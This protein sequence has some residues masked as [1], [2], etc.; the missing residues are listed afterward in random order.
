MIEGH[1]VTKLGPDP[2]ADPV[3]GLEQH[4]PAAG[5][6]QAAGGGEAGGA[7][8]DDDDLGVVDGR[9]LH[10]RNDQFAWHVDGGLDRR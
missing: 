4:H 3:P 2:A 5:R 7:G 8:A 6:Q 10:G 9:V 1:A